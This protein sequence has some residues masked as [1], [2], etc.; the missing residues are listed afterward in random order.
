M[1][2]QLNKE[3]LIAENSKKAWYL[4]NN[5]VWTIIFVFP[6]L[7]FSISFTSTNTGYNLS[8]QG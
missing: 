4:T 2:V 3:E 5:I 8:L 6:V 1:F 7:P